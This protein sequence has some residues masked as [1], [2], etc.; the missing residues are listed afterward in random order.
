VSRVFF[1]V[2][3]SLDGFLAGP[4]ASPRN[5]LGNGG[6]ALH[7]WMF[8][9]ATFHRMLGGRGGDTGP[10][11]AAVQA[12]FARA[13]AYVMG[14]R[15]FDEGE[16]AWSDDPPF[17]APVF[18]LTRNAREPWVRKGGTTFW[19]VTD[20]MHAALGRAREA[21][22]GKDVRICGGADT[23]QQFVAEDLIDDFTIHTAPLLL[24]RGTRL[25]DELGGWKLAAD[26]VATQCSSRAAHVH[27]RVKH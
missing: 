25:F 21:A 13:G 15:M 6:A 10:D 7:A 1:D 2:A 26:V 9:T 8:A 20:G 11:D 17:H 14:R 23:I 18:V 19:F 16:I 27:Y 12:V 3:L 4:D 22:R 24:G 5:P